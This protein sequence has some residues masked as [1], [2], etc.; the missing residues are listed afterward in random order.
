MPAASEE[1][2]AARTEEI[3]DACSALYET[4]PFKQITLGKIGAKTSFT[5]T[6]IYNYFQTK[7]EIFLALLEREYRAWTADLAALARAPVPTGA[8]ADSFAR[9]LA[10]R[11]S[12]LKLMSMNLYDMEAG[13][14]LENLVS[15]KRAYHASMQAVC[16]CLSAHFSVTE[17]QTQQFLYAFYPFL[18]GVYP[19]T[20]ATEKQQLAMELAD[21]PFRRYSV[22]EMAGAFTQTLVCGFA[23]RTEGDLGT[24]SE[25]REG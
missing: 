5:R 6:S 8:F 23:A 21:V 13:S 7:E 18:F 11:G 16:A 2:T 17:E 14:R 20:Q 1:L 15:F 12:M 25:H 24:P 3:I 19:Y 10:R 9:L 4:M 22:R